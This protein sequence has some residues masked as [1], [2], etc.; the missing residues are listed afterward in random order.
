MIGIA[1]ASRHYSDAYKASWPECRAKSTEWNGIE[2]VVVMDPFCRTVR[3]KKVDGGYERIRFQCEENEPELHLMAEI[4]LISLW[5]RICSAYWWFFIGSNIFHKILFSRTEM[6]Q[7]IC[8][9][10]SE[11]C[12]E[13]M[14]EMLI[15]SAKETLKRHLWK[16]HRILLILRSLSRSR[17]DSISVTR[18]PCY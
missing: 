11:N 5:F 1:W 14:L 16:D 6:F 13:K 7:L 4:L 12:G 18:T 10:L 3:V 9:W 8:S 2:N 15:K 17:T